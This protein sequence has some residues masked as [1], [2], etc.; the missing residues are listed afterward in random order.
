MDFAQEIVHEWLRGG[1][2]LAQIAGL[3]ALTSGLWGSDG[4]QGAQ[5]RLD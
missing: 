4:R 5:T 3:L 2:Q 1:K